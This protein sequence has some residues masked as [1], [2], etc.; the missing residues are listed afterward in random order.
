MARYGSGSTTDETGSCM[1]VTVYGGLVEMARCIHRSNVG[2]QLL[3]EMKKKAS[4]LVLITEC[5][6]R[7]SVMCAHQS[8]RS[9]D[10]SAKT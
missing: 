6:H 5:C 3:K 8:S 10:Q 4:A 1:S 2:V 9:M 7:D